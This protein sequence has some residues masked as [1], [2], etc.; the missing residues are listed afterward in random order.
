VDVLREM[1]AECKRRFKE[2][3]SFKFSDIKAASELI[4]N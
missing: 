2:W 1:A 3:T 4:K